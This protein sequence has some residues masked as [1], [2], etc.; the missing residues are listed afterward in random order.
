[1]KEARTAF[2]ALLISKGKEV[3]EW[4]GSRYKSHNV[5][6][7]WRWFVLGWQMRGMNK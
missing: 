4:D 3:P 6:M 7:Y 1:M 5:Q 2:E